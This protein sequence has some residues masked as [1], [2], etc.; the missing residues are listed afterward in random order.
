LKCSGGPLVTDRFCHDFNILAERDGKARKA[1]NGK[2][3]ELAARHLGH[4]GLAD[5]NRPAWLDLF[6]AAFFHPG[7]DPLDTGFALILNTFWPPVA[8]C[9][10]LTAPRRHMWVARWMAQSHAIAVPGYA[11]SGGRRVCAARP[12]SSRSLKLCRPAGSVQYS[13]SRRH[14][15]GESVNDKVEKD[16]SKF[17][18]VTQRSLCS[19]PNVFKALRLQ[20]EEDVKTRNALRPNNS[21]Y[22]FSVAENGDDF[23]VLLEAKG[24]RKSVIFSL[25]EH[26]ISVRDDKGKTMFEVTLTFNDE[27]ECRLIVNKEERDLWKVRRMALEELLFRG[28]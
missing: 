27:G 14:F 12:H 23:T 26:A 17:D 6:Q 21:P 2:L 20:V 16:T 15:G 7:V 4:A 1:L 5:A 22:E 9:V 8:Y 3:P 24:L 13:W 25:A 10:L 11:G 28:Y 19:L 18:W